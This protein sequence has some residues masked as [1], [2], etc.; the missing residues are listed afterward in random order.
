M[1]NKT[2]GVNFLQLSA[3]VLCVLEGAEVANQTL[4]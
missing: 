2:R 1:K 3:D 4:Y